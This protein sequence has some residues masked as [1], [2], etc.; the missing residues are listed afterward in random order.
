VTVPPSITNQAM[1]NAFNQTFGD[2]TYWNKITAAGL[3][4]LAQARQAAYNGPAIDDLPGLSKTEK[5]SLAATFATWGIDASAWKTTL[6]KTPPDVTNQQMIN[7]FSNVFGDGYWSKVE[8]ASLGW[9]AQDRATRN[10]LYSGR[11]IEDLPTLTDDEKKAIIDELNKN[12]ANTTRSLW[13]HHALPGLHGP[14][15]PGGGWVPEAFAVVRQTKVRAVKMFVPDLQ[16]VEVIRLREI[17][18]DMF[19]MGRLFSAQLGERRPL[20]LAN[21]TPEDAAR[22]FANEVAE[23]HDGN[24][25]MNRAHR[26]ANIEYFEVHNEPNL[27]CEGLEVNWRT[28]AEFAR[29]FNAVVDTLKQD[30][31]KAKFGFPGLSPGAVDGGRPIDM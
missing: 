21:A 14:G 22:W 26:A 2:S 1:I 8:A 11:A 23:H 9:I 13:K 4:A 17:N 18:P 29:F 15:D 10:S 12:P 24:N 20:G 31:P 16:P 25:P 27:R 3:E 7:V 28:G 19:I 6:P 5:E 30:Y